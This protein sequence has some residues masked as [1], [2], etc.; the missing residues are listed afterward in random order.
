[1]AKSITLKPLRLLE[2]EP[3]QDH[4]QDEL[5]LEPFSRTVAGAA[6]GTRGPFTIGV[7]G[8]WGF[9]KTSVL[10][11]A[12]SLIDTDTAHK[13]VV[14]VW[15][16]A[17]QYEKE[18]STLV[19]PLIATIV[20]AI[21][22]KRSMLAKGADAAWTTLTRALR[23]IAYG[24]SAKAKVKI[25][26]F[27]ELE[28][29]FVAKEMIEREEQLR[30]RAD[31]LLQRSLYYD[32]FE[33]LDELGEESRKEKDNAPK[34]VVF[35]DDLDR[36]LPDNGLKLL[37]SIKLVLAQPG[38]VFVLAVD[39]PVL[40]DYLVKRYTD[41]GIEEPGKA[42]HY[43]DK[44]VQ[45]PFPLPD[46]RGR[47]D[48]YLKHLVKKR[49]AL[50]DDPGVSGLVLALAEVLAIGSAWNPR[51]LVRFVNNLLVDRHIF[52]LRGGVGD[53]TEEQFLQTIAVSRALRLHL[54][55]HV[56]RRLVDDDRWCGVLAD[57]VKKGEKEGEG[58]WQ[59]RVAADDGWSH[60]KAV[61]EALQTQDFL[62]DLLRTRLGQAWLTEHERRRTV[63]GFLAAQ[64]P[65]PAP[66]PQPK[67]EANPLD[68][69]IRKALGK[70]AGEAIGDEELKQVET[71]DLSLQPITDADLAGL[72]GLA[73]LQILGL[74]GTQVTDAGLAHLKGLGRLQRLDLRGTQVSDAGLAHLAGLGSL[75][76]LDLTDTQVSDAGLAHLK[77]LGS[78][79]ALYLAGTQVS[80][81]GLAHLEGLGTLQRLDLSGTQVTDAGL[82]HL[83]GLAGLQ[84]LHL[85]GTKVSD[86]GLAHLAGLGTLQGLSLRGT[87]VSDGGLEHLEAL[88]GLQTLDLEDTQVTSTGLAHLEGLRRL[89]WL[90]LS[91]TRVTKKG[92]AG[93]GKKLPKCRIVV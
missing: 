31:P 1:M 40:E 91:G 38:F 83:K 49:P 72:K 75:Q 82:A 23:A 44:I 46:H 4:E 77:W 14:T 19:V 12:K 53:L 42:R 92:L 30:E 85:S 43:L 93:L 34:I 28:A 61:A 86:A 52:G 18:E 13:Q 66:K 65:E 6:V 74:G 20:R 22:Q 17:W 73:G 81:A 76:A 37:E 45:L 29:G 69:A 16:N 68:A 55:S 57:A 80:D 47:F 35:V 56:Y 10:K 11:Q 3:V 25:P 26:G 62:V 51:S 90:C 36:C 59:T 7:F 60:R 24:F 70:E 33:T 71:L 63:D 64:R 48:D 32:A 67:A 89:Q 41:L 78:L 54:R 88:G 50:K 79:A 21:E 39:R 2:D 84:G 5:R 8:D 87:K 27:P 15:F 58:A 9:G